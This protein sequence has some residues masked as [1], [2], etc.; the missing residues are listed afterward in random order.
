MATQSTAGN[1]N[2][3]CQVVFLYSLW[4][5]GWLSSVCCVLHSYVVVFKCGTRAADPLC[6]SRHTNTVGT[7]Q[8]DSNMYTHTSDTTQR[9]SG[10]TYRP[11]N[12]RISD[13][14]NR[15]KRLRVAAG[16]RIRQ[17]TVVNDKHKTLESKRVRVSVD[18]QQPAAATAQTPCINAIACRHGTTANTETI[19]RSTAMIQRTIV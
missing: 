19:A 5:C 7:H 18:R 4:V 10:Y 13:L 14:L 6:Y 3:G 17:T 11:D 15:K 2:S 1:T 16:L 8:K 9:S 12:S